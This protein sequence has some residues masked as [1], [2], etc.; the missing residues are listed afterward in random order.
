MKKY[1]IFTDHFELRLGR[2]RDARSLTPGE[3]F[4]EY[5]MEDANAPHLE[6]S[7]N[8]AEEAM[9]EFNANY[10]NRKNTDPVRGV[11]GWLLYGNVAFIEIN[12]YDEDG[13]YDQ[14]GD[15]LAFSAGG[16]TCEEGE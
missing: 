5:R 8:T 10:A 4:D 2:T 11:V 6:A 7:F 1:E 16:Y 14:S 3:V 12:E 9:A 13:E 15:V